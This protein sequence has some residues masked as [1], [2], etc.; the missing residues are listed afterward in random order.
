MR[1]IVTQKTR[2]RPV[3]QSVAALNE[4][5]R[6]PEEKNLSCLVGRVAC[7]LDPDG[8]LT[9][10]FERVVDVP[11]VN[12]VE[13][14]FVEAFTRIQRPTCTEC[15]GA[16]RVEMRLATQLNPSAL[17]NVISKG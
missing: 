8:M 11:A 6:W 17:A 1:Y 3:A 13:L 9:P 16:G 15:W 12:A 7:R 4:L 14:G 2:A 5:A 10:C